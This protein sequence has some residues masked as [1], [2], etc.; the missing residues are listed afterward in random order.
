MRDRRLLRGAVGLLAILLLATPSG[1]AAATPSPASQ[2]S[3]AVQAAARPYR[4]DLADRRDLVAQTN[5]VQCVGASLQPMLN[6]MRSGADRTSRTQSTLQVLARSLSGPTREGFER[7]GASV[8]GWT[9]ALNRLGAG[10][11]QMAG[12]DTLADAMTAAAI[13]IARTGKPVGLLMWSGRHAWVMTGFTATGDPH[14]AS[15]FSV[16]GAIV[17][18]P[19]YPHGSATWGTSPKPGATLSLATLGKQFVPRRRGT[20]PGAIPGS[21]DM[22]RLAGKYVI[23][24]PY[25]QQLEQP[26]YPRGI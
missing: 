2:S 16:T 5:F 10:R 18:D 12:F 17:F 24:E 14:Q 20:W 3:S 11:Y 23:V 15:Q 21:T 26:R 8:R 4:L 22:S 9:A 6:V 1:A 25:L 7:Q 13:A 19:L